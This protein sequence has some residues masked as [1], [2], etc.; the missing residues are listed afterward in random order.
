MLD[1]TTDRSV[2]CLGNI[3]LTHSLQTYFAG[4]RKAGQLWFVSTEASDRR[5]SLENLGMEGSTRAMGSYARFTDLAEMVCR[6]RQT[7]PD[8]HNL[9]ELDSPQ[10]SDT[11]PDDSDII[12]DPEDYLEEAESGFM[13]HGGPDDL[14]LQHMGIYSSRSDPYKPRSMPGS[15]TSKSIVA[16]P[17]TV[18]MGSV[19]LKK[20]ATGRSFTATGGA[21]EDV[22]D[23]GLEVE[24]AGGQ[25][26]HVTAE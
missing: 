7:T 8:R 9:P 16:S 21:T 12:S 11:D 17:S 24:E 10:M 4:L 1:T 15:Q 20:Q 2:G 23:A 14:L 13:S 25:T 19:L 26:T 22:V 5:G 18:S 3:I 6:V